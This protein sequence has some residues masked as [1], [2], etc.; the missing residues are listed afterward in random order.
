MREEFLEAL[1]NANQVIVCIVYNGVNIL[2][3]V[4]NPEDVCTYDDNEIVLGS[5]NNLVTLLGDINYDEDENLYV[6]TY[7]S[8]LTEIS[9]S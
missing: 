6:F 9:V 8:L 7:D 1:R 4:F 3:A 2:N 5:G